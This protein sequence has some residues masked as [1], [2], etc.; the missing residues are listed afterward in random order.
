VRFQCVIL[1]GVTAGLA[2]AYLTLCQAR[3]FADNLTA[4][5]G[6]IAV[7][8]VY[9]GR[10]SPRGIAFGAVLFSL[11]GALQRIIQVFG[12]PFPYELAL[13]VPHLLVLLV[14]VASRGRADAEP[15]ALGKPYAR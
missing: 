5:R 7:A 10:W 15:L 2:G 11:A 6:F 13:I 14:L 1:A 8:L 12:I 9:F 3:M 4:G